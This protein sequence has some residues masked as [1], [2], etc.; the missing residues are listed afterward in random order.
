MRSALLKKKYVL[1]ITDALRLKCIGLYKITLV[2]EW[3]KRCVKVSKHS[4]R[5]F[6]DLRFHFYSYKLH[7]WATS[8]Y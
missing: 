8:E 3:K 1:P 4:M 2:F 5:N 6:G 7:R